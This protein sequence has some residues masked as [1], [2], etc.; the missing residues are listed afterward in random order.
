MVRHLKEAEINELTV[1][2]CLII[3][4][5]REGERVRKGIAIHWINFNY[6]MRLLED[7]GFLNGAIQLLVFWGFFLS[8][9]QT[10]VEAFQMREFGSVKH[11]VLIQ[12]LLQKE[13]HAAR[14]TGLSAAACAIL[15]I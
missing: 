11:T 1:F 15:M 9:Y 2:I 5:L 13:S 10:R 8:H 14:Q 7:L 4:F 12:Q 6:E 3:C